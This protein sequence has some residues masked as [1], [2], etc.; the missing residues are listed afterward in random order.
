MWPDL[1][2]GAWLYV[3]FVSFSGDMEINHRHRSGSQTTAIQARNHLFCAV[4]HDRGYYA[5][6]IAVS[7]P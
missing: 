7:Y 3:L 2:V 6:N 4:V 5:A 1:G